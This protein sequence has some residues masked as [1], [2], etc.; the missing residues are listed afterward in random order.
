VRKFSQVSPVWRSPTGLGGY[1]FRVFPH[2]GATVESEAN[3][4]MTRTTR[5]SSAIFSPHLLKNPGKTGVSDKKTQKTP[6]K[7]V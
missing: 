3:G 7:T 1:D 2:R 4:A 6:R 5:K